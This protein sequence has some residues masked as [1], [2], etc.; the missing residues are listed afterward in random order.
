MLH[1]EMTY[2]LVKISASNVPKVKSEFEIRITWEN[3]FKILNNIF[4]FFFFSL[5]LPTR[6]RCRMDSMCFPSRSSQN[7]NIKVDQIQSWKMS[8]DKSPFKKLQRWQKESQKSH[9]YLSHFIIIITF[10]PSRKKISMT[11]MKLLMSLFKIIT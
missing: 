1:L 10:V 3:P 6:Q 9:R 11:C 5:Y 8:W 7:K 4:A 2:L